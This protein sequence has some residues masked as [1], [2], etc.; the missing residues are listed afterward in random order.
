MHLQVNILFLSPC[1][2]PDNDYVNGMIIVHKINVKYRYREM[3][4]VFVPRI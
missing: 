2:L 1:N 4:G 3:G